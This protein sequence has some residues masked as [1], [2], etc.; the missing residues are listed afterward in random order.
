[1]PKYESERGYMNSA[2]AMVQE[3]S[4]PSVRVAI[5]TQFPENP[6]MPHGGVE[7]VSINLTQALG[8]FADLDLHVVTVDR[9]IRVATQTR[10]E[11][12]T[13]H[14]LPNI[15]RWTLTSALG[16][17]RQQLQNYIKSLRPD[18]VHAHD[19]YGLMVK[20][21]SLPRVFTIHGFIYGDTLVSGQQF[22]RLRSLIWR[23]IE[24]SGWADQPHIISISPYVRERLTGVTTSIVHFRVDRNEGKPIIFSAAV[25]CP[26]KNTLTLLDAFAKLRADGSNAELRLA[27]P[28]TEPAY[29]EALRAKI[30][31]YKLEHV[32]TL[33]GSIPRDRI[34]QELSAAS[35]FALVSLE[36]NSPMGIEEAMA[37]GIPVVT[38]NRCGMPYMV[39]HGETGFLVNPHDPSDIARRFATLLTD[40]ALRRRMGHNA[41]RLAQERFHPAVVARRT[42]EVYLEAL[43]R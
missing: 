2:T 11:R 15:G 18:I 21:L 40:E 5:V 39:Q 22:A 3:E 13:V 33:L 9:T 14:R 8:E 38:S 23:Y 37:I 20:G 6:E 25:I 10:W 30:A 17:G 35:V 28:V 26:R 29:G 24:T 34:V 43:G 32:V 41:Q 16:A 36:E 4:R 42:R 19:T 1:M 12:A 27:G 31:H 7:A